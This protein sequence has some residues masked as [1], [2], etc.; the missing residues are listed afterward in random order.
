MGSYFYHMSPCK[1][2]QYSLLTVELV[3][4]ADFNVRLF[5]IKMNTEVTKAVWGDCSLVN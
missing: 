1:C 3:E 5:K 2:L 4:S